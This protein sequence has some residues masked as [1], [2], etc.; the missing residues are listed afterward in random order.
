MSGN[1]CA[2]F[3][4]VF[5]LKN[6]IPDLFICPTIDAVFLRPFNLSTIKTSSI[7]ILSFK[8]KKLSGE[9]WFESS[10]LGQIIF[11]FPQ[12]AILCPAN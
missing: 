5:P 3:I 6:D 1:C 11:F 2:F 8:T 4:G 10:F 7:L 9:T 12:L